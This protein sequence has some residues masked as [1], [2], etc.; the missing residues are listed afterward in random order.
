MSNERDKEYSRTPGLKQRWDEEDAARAKL[1]QRA[2]ELFLEEQANEIFA[3]IDECLTRLDKVLQRFDA[4]IERVQ[5]WEHLG[6][7]KLR[8]V[9]KVKPT[10]SDRQLTLRFTIDG[11][12]IFFRDECYQSSRDTQTLIRL[13]VRQVEQ[14]LQPK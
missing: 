5:G 2:K 8:H 11:R 12:K 14:F 7:Q 4:S 1:E 6:D 9:A 10:Q 3:P 13:I